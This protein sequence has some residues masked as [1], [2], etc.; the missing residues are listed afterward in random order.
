MKL[1]SILLLLC[2]LAL[3][4]VSTGGYLYYSALKQ[5]ALKE[6]E[7]QA[8]TRAEMI[9]KTL[10][11]FLSENVRPVKLLAGMR[12]IRQVLVQHSDD[13]LAEADRILDEFRQTL[14]ADV[15][16]VTD[17]KG[18][19]I[20]SSNRNEADSFVGE[21]F[22][23]RPYFQRAISGV[24]STY[25]ALGTT[26]G[27]R[28]AYYSH[29]VYEYGKNIAA[30]VAVMKVSAELI[31]KELTL[32]PDE[33]VIVADR[34][35]IIFISSRKDWLYQSLRKLSDK[36]T[37]E[38]SASMQFGKGPWK[39][40]GL[41][42]HKTHALDASKN[43]YMIYQLEM[44]HYPGW[45]M[46]YLLNFNTVFKRISSPVIK[47]ILL[48]CLLV[49]L[50]VFILYRKAYGEI[51]RRK[52]AERSLHTAKE[53][54]SRYSKELELLVKKRTEEIASILKYTPD[55]VYIRD[56]E[57]RYLMVNPK[58]EELFGIKNEDIRGKTLHEV[59]PGELATE[60]EESDK[61]VLSEKIPVQVENSI[62]HKDGIHTY[63][64]V[65]FP[66]YDEF[67]Q[68]SS[69]G[70]IST[71]ITELKKTQH[72]L[73]RISEHIITAQ[74][75]ERAAI[76]RELHDELGQMLT[77][78]RMDAVWIKKRLKETDAEASERAQTLCSLI[79]STIED[80]RGIA[81][82][83]RPGVLDNLGLADALE[84]NT[85]D[86]EKRTGITC[87]FK[88]DAVSDID[89]R[90][91]TAAYRIAQE[92]LTNVARHA[93]AGRAE[94]SLKADNHVL[95]LSIA[96]DGCGFNLLQLNETQGLGL[97]GMRERAAIIGG[98]LDIQSLPGKGTRI[99]FSV[100]T[101]RLTDL[102]IK[103]E[104]NQSTVGR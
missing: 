12:E 10:S 92:S 86:F 102:M 22:A 83:L 34:H 76:A 95:I 93:K 30:G 56:T 55:A 60:Y 25:L 59:L 19:T 20:A 36:E 31:E 103:Y 53:E 50:A 78:L 104:N 98:M 33:R 41:E 13:S 74:E 71:D 101:D 47:G 15:C 62:P 66:I 39:H 85:A 73:R 26:S 46:I 88:Y 75:K 63:L 61:T 35:G 64:S 100:K 72:Q 32:G 82:C 23:F 44:A 84:W 70:G 43:R 21:N 17:D 90:I 49:S 80:V 14:N 4:S 96:D 99:T 3:L 91:A 27:K 87:V 68:M 2:M 37:D 45:K 54:L 65:K 51:L 16:Y 94:V 42:I 18:T 48:L 28:G 1:R 5:A 40:A 52:E 79:D 29:P 97:T 81:R 9:R 89:N 6:T 67:G 38:I 7:R 69:I 58:Y 24:S 8:V 77:A 57:G 11:S